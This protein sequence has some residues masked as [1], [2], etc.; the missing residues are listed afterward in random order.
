MSLDAT[1]EADISPSGRVI[2]FGNEKGTD[3][4]TA[5]ESRQRFS[6]HCPTCYRLHR[7]TYMR[8]CRY[9]RAIA[10]TISQHRLRRRVSRA[11]FLFLGETE[12]VVIST[13]SRCRRSKKVLGASSSGKCTSD[14]ADIDKDNISRMSV[15]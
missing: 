8:T 2:I 1:N 15:R 10:H 12:P 11:I 3:V 7:V 6:P 14:V 9:I 13:P 4:K 5:L